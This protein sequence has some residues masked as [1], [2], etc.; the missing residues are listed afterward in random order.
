[1]ADIYDGKAGHGIVYQALEQTAGRGQRGRAWHTGRN[2]NIALS[3]V[4]EPGHVL[5]VGSFLLGAAAALAV[6][7]WLE[8]YINGCLI[9][10]PNDIYVHDKKIAGILI[11]SVVRGNSWTY[12]VIGIGAN[13]NQPGFE[14]E[15]DTAVSLQMLTG[16]EYDIMV[17]GRELCACLE[18]EWQLLQQEPGNV[19]NRYNAHLFRKGMPV[20]FREEN[21]VFTA[22]VQEVTASGGLAVT[23][24]ESEMI[25]TTGVQWLIA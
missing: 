15:L 5:P 24:G 21:R 8:K 23:C 17:L 12:A 14:P 25:L 22:T 10:W 11:E 13:I 16:K 2:R 19:M 3:A 1:M 4:L 9:K 6:R 20:R 18:Q 7:N